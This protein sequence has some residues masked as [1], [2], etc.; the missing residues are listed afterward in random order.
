MKKGF[1]LIELL[2]VVAIIAI[3]AAIAVPNF[4][5]AQ[6]RSK[7]SRAKSDQRS[8]ATAIEAYFVD[9][10]LYPAAGVHSAGT[11][12]AQTNN[13][14]NGQQ[15]NPSGQGNIN[16]YLAKQANQGNQNPKLQDVYSFAAQPT[17]VTGSP[18]MTLTTPIGYIT[19]YPADPFVDTK[20][21]TFCYFSNSS[22]WILWSP[23]PDTD[24][25]QG[26]NLGLNGTS[27]PANTV[28]TLYNIGESQPSLALMCGASGS[29]SKAFTYDPTNGTVSPGDVWRVKQ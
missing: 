3:L 13:P 23:G 5:E 9:N 28:E 18:M 17:G 1:T 16:E 11:I 25:A 26:T 19:S 12:T 22:G 21:C 10:N 20:G 6:V 2:I 15:R 27:G 14:S 24:E 7:V 29:P 4:L 8:L